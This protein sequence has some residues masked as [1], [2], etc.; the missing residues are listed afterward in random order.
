MGEN[1]E[2]P[3]HLTVTFKLFKVL[4]KVAL[5]LTLEKRR[6]IERMPGKPRSIRILLLPEELP[7][8]K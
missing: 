6:L 4:R 1:Y 3:G 5:V 2:V 7:D 8:L